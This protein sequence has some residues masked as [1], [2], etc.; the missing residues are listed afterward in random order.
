MRTAR[1]FLI[2][3]KDLGEWNE[4]KTQFAAYKA[5]EDLTDGKNRV[6]VKVVTQPKVKETVVEVG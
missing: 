3:E 1:Y 2:E 4:F 6:V 5:A